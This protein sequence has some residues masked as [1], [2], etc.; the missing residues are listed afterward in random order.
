MRQRQ[1]TAH[2][3]NLALVV[4]WEAEESAPSPAPLQC[5]PPVLAA[6]PQSASCA[7]NSPFGRGAMASLLANDL[8]SLTRRLGGNVL[9]TRVLTRPPPVLPIPSETLAEMRTSLK[10]VRHALTHNLHLEAAEGELEAAKAAFH[11]WHATSWLDPRDSRVKPKPASCWTVEQ[12][13]L[14]G[15]SALYAERL[16]LPRLAA[17]RQVVLWLLQHAPG[18]PADRPLAWADLGSGTC[19]ACLGCRLAL[20][21]HAGGTQP[22]A[23]YAID[24]ASSGAR[25]ARAF[26]AMCL[27]GP[28]RA[29][30]AMCSTSKH[31]AHGRQALLPGQML[32][33]YMECAEP[34]IG[35]LAASLFGQLGARR[36]AQPHLLVASF[37]LHYLKPHEKADFFKR[38]RELATAPLLL[39]VIKGIGEVQ[40]LCTEGLCRSVHYGLHYVIGQDRSPRVVEAHLCLIEPLSPSPPPRASMHASGAESDGGDLEDAE[41][42]C[43]VDGGDDAAGESAH[44]SSED[45]GRAAAA[46]AAVTPT[47][48]TTTGA[49]RGSEQWVLQTFEAI[50][51]RI[52]RDGILSGVSMFEGAS[53]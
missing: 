12:Y 14:C 42:D 50:E 15:F 24:I 29:F 17:A 48:R 30:H 19:A 26:H 9:A 43:N 31:S 18:V 51:R 39:L 41:A 5:T 13:A 35:S 44:A 52:R 16:H 23:A 22:F 10:L 49:P 34:G 11:S 21:E 20:Q 25:F 36:A 8:V 3:R 1:R 32:D 28:S 2:A 6:R 7:H 4:A 53:H 47:T 45:G 37:S 46:A 27:P 38:L 40:Q 33:Q